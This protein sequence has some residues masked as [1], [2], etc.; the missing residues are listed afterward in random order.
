[1]LVVVAVALLAALCITLGALWAGQRGPGTGKVVELD[2]PGQTTPAAAA[3][4]LARAGVVEHP[5][6]FAWY[7]RVVRPSLDLEPGPHLLN[8]ALS[9]KEVVQR[10]ARL[11]SRTTT[12][13]VIPE[14]YHHLQIAERLHAAQVVAQ[15]SFRR[16]ALDKNLL[17]ELGISGTSVEGYLFP[18]TYELSVD[19]SPSSVIRSFVREMRKRL[20]K[21]RA[22]DPQ[23]VERLKR[24]F[25]WGEHEL[26]TLASVVE[27]EA[28]DRE[29]LRTV[30]SVFFNRLRDPEFRPKG[31]L[32]SDPTAAYGCLIAP[33]DA[34][35]CFGFSGRVTPAMLR[36]PMNR[37]NTYRH[38]GLP[39]GPI[40]NPG[41]LAIRAVLAPAQTDYLFF[42]ASGGRRHTFSRTFEEHKSVVR[43]KTAKLPSSE[44]KAEP[45]PEP[46]P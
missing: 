8:D 16:A 3:E 38:A 39:P 27:R 33:G 34:P 5:R 15:S 25:G 43:G 21:L 29:E 2:W 12:R 41:E 23:A 24:E 28:A 13:I 19:S 11:P 18:A 35:S 40:A 36:D 6:L 9:P 45:P 44:P 20:E 26:L 22:A 10:L 46:A 37:Y 30:A 1:V 7:L 14:G 17:R 4:L 31:T 42:F 32:Q